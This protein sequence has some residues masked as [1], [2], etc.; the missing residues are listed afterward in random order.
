MDNRKVL[1]ELKA[2]KAK[3][4]FKCDGVM[5][6]YYIPLAKMLTMLQN[7]FADDMYYTELA[8]MNRTD[9]RLYTDSEDVANFIRTNF[10]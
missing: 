10:I 3:Y 8:G 6:S 1:S 9:F 5:I 7:T 2:R 4:G